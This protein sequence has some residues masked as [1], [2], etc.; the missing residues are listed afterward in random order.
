VGGPGR[1]PI[2]LVVTPLTDSSDPCDLGVTEPDWHPDG[3]RLLVS[4]LNSGDMHDIAEVT[5]PGGAFSLLVDT[6]NDSWAADWSPDG[7]TM[8]HGGSNQ[9]TVRDPLTGIGVPFAATQ[10]G[11]ADTRPDWS[12]TDPWFVWMHDDG[13]GHH[14]ILRLGLDGT[15]L[16]AL[17]SYANPERALL[18]RWTP[19]GQWVLYNHQDGGGPVSIRRVSYD[20]AIDELVLAESVTPGGGDQ[21]GDQGYLPAGFTPGDHDG[22]GDGSPVREDC[23]DADPLRWPGNPYDVEFDG[24]DANCDGVD[25]VDPEGQRIVFHNDAHERCGYAVDVGD[26]DGDGWPEVVVGCTLLNG[27][28]GIHVF[29]GAALALGGLFG[30]GDARATIVGEGGGDLA[31]VNPIGDLTGDGIPDLLAGDRKNDDYGVDEG[32]VYL[33]PGSALLAQGTIAV[34]AAAVATIVPAV[35]ARIGE[36]VLEA[37]DRTGDG[38]PEVY[39]YGATPSQNW[40]VFDGSVLGAGGNFTTTDALLIEQGVGGGQAVPDL[41][42]DGVDEL[43]LQDGAG[44]AFFWSGN[45]ALLGASLT[46][47]DADFSYDASPPGLSGC[48]YGGAHMGPRADESDLDGD[49]L[50]DLLF[51]CNNGAYFLPGAAIVANGT[52]SASDASGILTSNESLTNPRPI[53][54]LDGG[55]A[56][57]YVIRAEYHLGAQAGGGDRGAIFLVRGEDLPQLGSLNLGDVAAATLVGPVT[58]SHLAA[59][60]RW[61]VDLSGDGAPDL[62]MGSVQ[63]DPTGSTQS[64]P[65]WGAF[66]IWSPL[67]E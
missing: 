20:G 37:S 50:P 59:R 54:D 55:G 10:D 14:N 44:I 6:S 4:C 60:M 65:D 17:T 16:L 67:W 9:I 56:D 39:V 28:G 51:R 26:L 30:P 45:P 19:D 40:Y 13:T 38:V 5:A 53:A 57:D 8:I 21:G 48:D 2:T 61:S 58:G 27:V 42:G 18:P 33:I 46:A 43:A 7:Q 15:N 22:D 63:W 34:T 35:H 12:P 3:D 1:G 64:D 24:V 25:W 23:D 32:K 52:A 66:W 47:G 36:I 62:L 11:L 29:S 31:H 41:D 49:G